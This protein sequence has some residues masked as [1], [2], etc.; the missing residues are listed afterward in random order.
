M[1]MRYD[2][3]GYWTE[4]K[5]EIVSKYA[6]AYSRILAAQQRLQHHYIDAFAGAGVHI[7]RATGDFILGSPLNALNV[8]PPFRQYHFIDLEGT[9][10]QSLRELVGDTTSVRLYQGDANKVLVQEV[11]PLVRFEDYRR[12]LCLLDPYGLH[13]DWDVVH[14]IGRMKSV[15][16][17]INFPTMDMNRNI[18][19]RN[20]EDVTPQQVVRMNAFWGDDSWRQ[21]AYTTRNLFELEM[22][23]ENANQA[24]VDA[25][26]ARLREAGFKHVP[27]ALPMRNKSGAVV[28]YLVF[29]SANT[30]A[31]NIVTQIFDKYRLRPR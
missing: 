7:S 25:Y 11:L 17:F 8:D 4:I 30:I 1:T 10:I 22:K 27:E 28:Y 12:A 5:L 24:V 13:L 9:R 23:T 31:S 16:V 14:Q 15:E 20:P 29:A 6:S 21:A 19:W 26:R 2:E 18:L 3:V